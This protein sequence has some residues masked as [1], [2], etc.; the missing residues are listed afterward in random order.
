MP[1][2][3][4]LWKKNLVK[5]C[6]CLFCEVIH[7]ADTGDAVVVIHSGWVLCDIL[8]KRLGW[9]EVSRAH[10]GN[11]EP[12]TWHVPECASGQGV[13]SV[14]AGSPLFGIFIN[15][16]QESITSALI[17]FADGTKTGGMTQKEEER[18]PIWGA[19]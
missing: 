17:K 2:K 3:G 6:W 18:A 19:S 9:K 5:I 15:D 8:T 4:D 10:T 1:I 13:L 11:A 14:C 12:A 16:L 7:L